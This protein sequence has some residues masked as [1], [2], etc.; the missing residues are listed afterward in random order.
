MAEE[1][2]APGQKPEREAVGLMGQQAAP[3]SQTSEFRTNASP[4]AVAEAEG[5][6][7]CYLRHMCQTTISIQV[8]LIFKDLEARSR[9]AFNIHGALKI[10]L[11]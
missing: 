1:Q 4:V 11:V 2:R 6:T 10:L 5:A 3:F 9:E 7:F 8:T